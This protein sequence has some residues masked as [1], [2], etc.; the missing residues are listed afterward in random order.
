MH[1]YGV[2]PLQGIRVIDFT[3][4]LPGPF[5][6]QRLVNMGAEVI[7]LEGLSGDP[8]RQL[9]AVFKEASLVFE[10]NNQGKK[11]M[12]IDLKR[13]EGRELALRLI[14]QADV[15]IE[16]FR[17]QVMHK[18]GLSYEDVKQVKPDIIYCSL[19]GYGQ[20]SSMAHLA[21]H[22]INYI[23]LSGLLSQLRDSE[24]RPIHPTI[25]LADLVGGIMS[26][27]AILAALL[28]KERTGEGS[29]IDLSLT[30]AM[31]SLMTTHCSIQEETG[32]RCGIPMI[33]GAIIS[34]HIYETA[35]QRY[36]SLGALEYKFWRHFCQAVDREDW[37]DAHLTNADVDNPIYTGMLE[38]FKSRSLR[39]WTQFGREIDCCLTPI[40]EIDEVEWQDDV[41]GVSLDKDKAKWNHSNFNRKS[42]P[43]LGEQTEGI[44]SSLLQL[45]KNEITDLK[46]KGV[47]L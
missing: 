19:T 26:N 40:L 17:P 2:E 10:V 3:Q 11:S 15:L 31:K 41:T 18:L 22:D 25:Q 47:V 46:N 43:E 24:G 37:L 6:T 28:K 42:P 30:E 23:A 44:L 29:Y 1:S 14:S 9:G 33:D 36:V 45:N 38:L 21:S 12:A 20:I 8:A 39:E 34:Y 35:D 4:Y 13:K 32:R 7:K 27:E 16:S 5:A